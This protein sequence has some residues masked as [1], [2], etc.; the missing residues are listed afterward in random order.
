MWLYLSM[1]L[2]PAVSSYGL[3]RLGR[4]LSMGC[5]GAPADHAVGSQYGI[6]RAHRLGPNLS[7]LSGYM[8]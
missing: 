6:P 3:P 5:P 1:C 4:N 8:Q 2:S 7:E